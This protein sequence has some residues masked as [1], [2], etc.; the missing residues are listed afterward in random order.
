VHELTIIPPVSV[1]H[2]VSTIGQFSFPIVLKYHIHTSGLIGSPTVP[3]RRKDDRSNELGIAFP[4][5]MYIRKAVGVVY[6]IVTPYF[7]TISQYLSGF[8]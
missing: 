8:G 1:C 2:H 7:S 3:S 4:Y 5:F 6:R